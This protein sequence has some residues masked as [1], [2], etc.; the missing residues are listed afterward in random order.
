MK[1]TEQFLAQI[2]RAIKNYVRELPAHP[3]H[4]YDPARYMLSLGGKRMRPFLVLLGNDLFGGK[5]AK[6]VP[7][8]LA[9]EL[10]HN[11]TLIHDDIMD[12]APLRRNRP[13]VHAKWGSSTAI[14]CGDVM[15]VHAYGQLAKS[16]AGTAA[17]L[18][19][20]NRAAAQ[21]CEGQ[22]LDMDFESRT[23]VSI[24]EYTHMIALKTAVLLGASLQMGAVLAGA[25]A[26]EAR[27]LCNFGLHTG[28]AF[29][30][31]DDLLDAYGDAVKTGKQRG[32]DIIANKK[33]WLLLKALELSDPKQ[34]QT[35][36]GLLSDKKISANTKVNKVITLYDQLD[37]KNLAEL[38][39]RKY[40]RKAMDL[41]KGL[42]VP[43][44]KK[45]PLAELAGMVLHREY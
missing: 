45:K 44:R 8:A 18:E 4:L 29:Q 15:M 32:G 24:E 39:M 34:K 27:K 28:I 33:T 13:T 12:R 36:S 38:E 41:L 43:D 6:A 1:R 14:L 30:L 10:F 20:F 40:Y 42:N 19:I 37:V 25:P 9:I 23:D 16:G 31:K 7:A 5:A 35:L 21:V 11:F 22:Q 17:L 3:A 26:R 2:D